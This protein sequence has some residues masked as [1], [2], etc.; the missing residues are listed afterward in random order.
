MYPK[1]SSFS[2]PENTQLIIFLQI[3]PILD[4][5]P[6]F[7]YQYPNPIHPKV[8]NTYR[9]ALPAAPREDCWLVGLLHDRLFSEAIIS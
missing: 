4:P 3:Y 2:I 1:I 6:K 9:W 8:E 7:F 5:N